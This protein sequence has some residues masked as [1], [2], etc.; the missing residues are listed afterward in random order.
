MSDVT[1]TSFS[2]VGTMVTSSP[3]NSTDGASDSNVNDAA[4][5]KD[6]RIIS[7]YV[8]IA[9]GTI[10]GLLV[11]AWLW[12]NRRRKSRVN[13]LILHVAVADLFVILGA[14]LIQLIWE[15]DRN[16]ALG[17]AVCRIVKFTQSFAMSSSN[18]MV[19]VLSIDRHQAIR[20][21]L[22]EPFPVSNHLQS[23]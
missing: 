18:Y 14:C 23:S 13:A 11:F 5:N 7:L 15:H 17:E 22:R 8:L 6:I 2:G 3:G 10:G 19:V 21:P 1:S 12:H 16:W 4:F 20:S 9:T